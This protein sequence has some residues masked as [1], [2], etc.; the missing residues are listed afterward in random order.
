MAGI[1]KPQGAVFVGY[2]AGGGD[3]HLIAIVAAKAEDGAP[4]FLKGWVIEAL[5]EEEA[6]REDI[7]RKARSGGGSW[8]AP[9]GQGRSTVKGG[10]VPCLTHS[11]NEG[12]SQP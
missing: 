4:S 5:A 6:E 1:A 7:M 8:A 3:S 11:S 10:R 2:G 12:G 9:E